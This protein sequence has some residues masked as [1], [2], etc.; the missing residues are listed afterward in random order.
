M[1]SLTISCFSGSYGC[2]I[3]PYLLEDILVVDIDT[4]VSGV[5]DI[6]KQGHGT[7]GLFVDQLWDF[8]G[9]LGLG[10]GVFPTLDESLHLLVELCPL[11]LPSADVRTITPKF[12]LDAL[13][14]LFQTGSLSLFLIFDET[15]NFVIEEHQYHKASS[16]TQLGCRSRPLV[17]I[18][19]L[20]ACTNSSTAAV[21]GWSVRCLRPGGSG[22]LVALEMGVEFLL[23]AS[24]L[25][26]VFFVRA[27]LSTQVKMVQESI[28]L[29]AYIC[30]PWALSPGISLRTLPR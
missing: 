10:N 16:Q 7:A 30:K 15:G 11:R 6:A 3:V 12:L 8:L 4:V 17:E 20:T 21:S 5:E 25:F 14:K 9:L 28:T 26:Q 19:S 13:D 24:Y 2:Y 29:R 18:G 1:Y 23:V 22:S 27:V